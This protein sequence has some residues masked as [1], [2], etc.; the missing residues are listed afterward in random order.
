MATKYCHHYVNL[1]HIIACNR[2]DRT[3]SSTHKTNHE[4]RQLLNM[5]QDGD[6]VVYGHK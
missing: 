2:S 6:N 3:S 1:F 5:I 4:E